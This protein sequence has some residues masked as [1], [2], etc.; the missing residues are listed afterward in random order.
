MKM[1]FTENWFIKAVSASPAKWQRA[2]KIPLIILSSWCFVRLS[3][4]WASA[5]NF[6]LFLLLRSRGV[7]WPDRRA[8]IFEFDKRLL[9]EVSAKCQNVF[10]FLST[11]FVLSKLLYYFLGLLYYRTPHISCKFRFRSSAP[12][13]RQ[14]WG[15]HPEG[16]AQPAEIGFDLQKVGTGTTPWSPAFCGKVRKISFLNFAQG[17]EKFFEGGHSSEIARGTRLIIRA[18]NANSRGLTTVYI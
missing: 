15:S 3:S 11:R 9:K 14:M 17:V 18:V 7:L 12:V 1:L 10:G 13:F 2:E 5:H 4:S 16:R 8:G 6:F